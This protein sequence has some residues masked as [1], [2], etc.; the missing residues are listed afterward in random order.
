MSD[1]FHPGYYLKEYVDINKISNAEFAKRIG[2]TDE[3]LKSLLK[4]KERITESL[5][6]KLSDEIGTS[7]E[8]WLN[9]Q[10]R[11]DVRKRNDTNKK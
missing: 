6:K 2:V 7:V 3:F 8:L 11:F 10:K 9:I 1:W 5:A 4:G